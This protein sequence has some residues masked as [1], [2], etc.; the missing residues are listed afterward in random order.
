MVLTGGATGRA[1]R[2]LVRTA[3]RGWR[4]VSV[5]GADSAIVV[6]GV[7][8]SSPAMVVSD[9]VFP[10]AT[11]RVAGG[12][13]VTSVTSTPPFRFRASRSTCCQ[14]R[15]RRRLDG[16]TLVRQ[17]VPVRGGGFGRPLPAPL[18][19]STA[20]SP[21]RRH[22]PAPPITLDVH[23][24]GLLSGVFGQAATTSFF[25][26]GQPGARRAPV[27]R[28]CSLG[29]W[30]TSPARWC[31]PC[32]RPLAGPSATPDGALGGLLVGSP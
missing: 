31:W 10:P 2:R 13:F 19:R 23:S 17:R 30:A 7:V 21:S 3:A 14:R 18:I 24:Y 11:S 29:S 22:P 20:A 27:G 28:R 26:V 15:C 4:P 25:A 1:L 9:A 16:V 6:Q 32:W 12:I 5:R 8:A